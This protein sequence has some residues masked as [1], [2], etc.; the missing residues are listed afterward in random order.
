MIEKRILICPL[1]WG[2]GHAVR[3]VPIIRKL[4][5]KGAV[6]VIAADG[7]PL[8]LLQKEFPTAEFV[9]FPGV[10][11]TYP[12]GSTSMLWSMMKQTPA[13]L[14]GIKEETKFITEIVPRLEIDAVIS[15]NR[16]GA[17]AKNVPSVYITHQIHIQTGNKITDRL[18]RQHHA[19]YMKNFHSVWIPDMESDGISGKLAHGSPIPNH[20]RYIG[21]LG[22]FTQLPTLE[23]RYDVGF[24][25]SGPEPQRSILEDDIL[26]QIHPFPDKKFALVRGTTQAFQKNIAKHITVI[27]LAD[28]KEIQELYASSQHI[29]CRSGYTSLMEMVTV[30]R[31]ATLIPTPGQTEQEYLAKHLNGKFGFTAVTQNEFNLAA[32][33]QK[34]APNKND[35]FILTSHLDEAI[36]Q[37]L[38][39]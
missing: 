34:T 13:L 9:H 8:A 6:P 24:I 11:V 39:I 26:H 28:A 3:C 36:D 35:E 25:L 10:S 37:L 4:I 38:A 29:V 20:A 14:K 18:A 5:E 31:N 16:F 17:Y 33:W 22:R 23:Q 12:S 21:L 19:R 7:G 15:D 30:G 32:L 27:S 2:L 1:D